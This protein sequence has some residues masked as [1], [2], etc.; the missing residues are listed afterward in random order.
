MHQNF[1]LN[2]LKAREGHLLTELALT[3]NL[4]KK[5]GKSLF[6]AWMFEES[7]T[8][9]GLSQAY[10]D[11]VVFG[12]SLKVL[13][14]CDPLLKPILEKLFLLAACECIARDLGWF[15][16]N[17]V[18]TKNMGKK[19]PQLIRLLCSELSPHA[20]ALVDS[21]GIP[22]HMRHAPIAGDWEKYNETDNFGELIPELQNKSKA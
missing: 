4:K 5:E 7:D 9:Q 6:E 20:I 3:L 21:F 14:T 10:A 8:I 1:L 22:A 19:L 17:K 15:V 13:K 11:R 12:A 2:I 18:L 16:T